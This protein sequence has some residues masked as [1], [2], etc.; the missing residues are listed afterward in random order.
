MDD[1]TDVSTADISKTHKL[2][3]KQSKWKKV[4]KICILTDG[5]CLFYT[6]F[7]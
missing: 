2:T 5:N 3:A 1:Q 6:V 4:R 7:D